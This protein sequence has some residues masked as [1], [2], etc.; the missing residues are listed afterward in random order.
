MEDTS[1]IEAIDKMIDSL[2]SQLVELKRRRNR[3][4]RICNLPSE[5]LVTIFED[6]RGVLY[7]PSLGNNT[8]HPNY[9][10]IWVPV[11]LVCRRFREV[12]L[13][14]R[15]LW[16][17]ISPSHHAQWN[18]LCVQRS[19][20]A[21][22]RVFG[23]CTKESAEYWHRLCTAHLDKA[24]ATMILLPRPSPV[25][26]SLFIDLDSEIGYPEVIPSSLLRN[27]AQSLT[28]LSL[29]DLSIRLDD[30]PFM[31]QLR[32]IKFKSIRTDPT[33]RPLARFFGQTPALQ[34][35]SISW[36]LV[37]DGIDAADANEIIDVP[38]RVALPLLQELH[39]RDSPAEAW[40]ALRI[41][42]TP[43]SAFCVTIDDASSFD[44]TQRTL[45]PNRQEAFEAWHSFARTTPDAGQLSHGRAIFT[46]SDT[47]ESPNLC[48][49]VFGRPPEDDDFGK[50]GEA[51]SAFY[52]QC[53]ILDRA[54]PLLRC[55]HTLELRA[56]DCVRPPCEGLDDVYGVRFLDAVNTLV[57]T[58]LYTGDE[59]CID[60]IRQWVVSRAGKIRHVWFA[61]CETLIKEVM[62]EW[63]RDQVAPEFSWVP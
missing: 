37:R 23:K 22:L 51:T 63:Q 61:Q 27:V 60:L 6:V 47:H 12:A 14:A 59:E 29:K 28:T 24:H 19:E 30:G 52:I 46:D 57:L 5:I 9:C 38:A 21:P 40:A 43:K 18:T 39:I 48:T 54:H 33:F 62:K 1:T 15:S 26:K 25:M 34:E 44:D 58:E 36:L 2:E 41:M 50:P 3:L 35:V 31:P 10:C 8:A 32:R 4:K 17:T 11:M 53:C 16:T 13:R 56:K 7:T 20:E 45:G 49:I 55:V 42:P